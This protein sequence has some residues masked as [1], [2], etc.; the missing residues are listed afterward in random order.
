MFL[1]YTNLFITLNFPM[2][3]SEL[4]TIPSYLKASCLVHKISLNFA[5]PNIN[6]V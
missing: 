4:S 3:V 5:Y 6:I 2:F 1:S